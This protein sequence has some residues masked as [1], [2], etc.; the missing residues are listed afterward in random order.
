MA[1]SSVTRGPPPRSLSCPLPEWAPIASFLPSLPQ[2]LPASPQ[3]NVVRPIPHR[4]PDPPR[5]PDRCAATSARPDRWGRPATLL[6]VSKSDGEES[7]GIN[8]GA[9]T[10]CAPRAHRLINH[11]PTSSSLQRRYNSRPDPWGETFSEIPLVHGSAR[12]GCKRRPFRGGSEL[13]FEGSVDR[14][15]LDR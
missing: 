14:V 5:A 10:P 6:A 8:T 11:P 12:S 1:H 7:D 3:P 13:S 9:A 15:G 2:R 4:R